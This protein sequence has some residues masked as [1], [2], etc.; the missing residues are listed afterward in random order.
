M[1]AGGRRSTPTIANGSLAEDLHAQQTGEPFSCEYRMVRPD[2]RIV[3]LQDDAVLLRDGQ[4]EPLYWQGVRFDVTARKEAEMHLREAE[5][6]YRTL[7]EQIPAITYIDESRGSNESASWHTIYIS[8][9]VEHILGL[10]AHRM[11][12]RRRALGEHHP[13]G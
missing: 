9:Q 13:P 8:P 10:H 11:E 3:W 5:Q 1:S 6:R 7:V 12:R 2:G 4:G